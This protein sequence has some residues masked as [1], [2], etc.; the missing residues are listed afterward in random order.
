VVDERSL[1]EDEIKII[2][3]IK[4]NGSINNQQSRDNLGFGKDKNIDLFNSLI[5]KRM[6]RKEE[7]SSSTRY[8]IN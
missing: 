6:I 5:K 2:D 1:S 7:A 8:L 4:K 3:Y